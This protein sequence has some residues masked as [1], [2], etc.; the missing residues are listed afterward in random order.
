MFLSGKTR[1]PHRPKTGFCGR[2]LQAADTVRVYGSRSPCFCPR[3]LAETSIVLAGEILQGQGGVCGGV[4]RMAGRPGQAWWLVASSSAGWRQPW[5]L[6]R[7]GLEEAT[8]AAGRWQEPCTAAGPYCCSLHYWAAGARAAQQ[9]CQA[10][11]VQH[12]QLP[13]SDGAVRGAQRRLR[14]RWSADSS[15]PHCVS[16]QSLHHGPIM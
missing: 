1:R 12:C 5:P 11:A 16:E 2:T 13:P 9:Q 14:R 6:L 3:S 8:A 10:A 4:A 15:P 7:A